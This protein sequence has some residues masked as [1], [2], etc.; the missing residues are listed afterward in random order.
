MVL[1]RVTL[2]SLQDS[3]LLCYSILVF[4]RTLWGGERRRAECREH[5]VHLNLKVNLHGGGAKWLSKQRVGLGTC[6][7]CQTSL[8]VEI[9]G[10]VPLNGPIE[11]QNPDCMQRTVESW[12]HSILF[13]CNRIQ[14]NRALAREVGRRE[15]S[16]CFVQRLENCNNFQLTDSDV[17]WNTGAHYW[18]WNTHLSLASYPAPEGGLT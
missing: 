12:V 7:Q 17:R 13:K 6:S 4:H 2:I 3:A 15:C 16:T 8:G 11:M 10:K 9:L 18:R 1:R 5:W 14:T